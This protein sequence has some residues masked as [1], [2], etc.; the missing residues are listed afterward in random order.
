MQKRWARTC[1]NVFDFFTKTSNP[2]YIVK[3]CSLKKNAINS[4]WLK[5]G[6][7]CKKVFSI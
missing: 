3:S 1:L 2:K 6:F 5:N 7:S 4:F